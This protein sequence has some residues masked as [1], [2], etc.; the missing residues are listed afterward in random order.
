MQKEGGM[1]FNFVSLTEGEIAMHI[2]LC[3]C[4]ENIRIPEVGKVRDIFF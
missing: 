3:L 1:H 2:L 4:D